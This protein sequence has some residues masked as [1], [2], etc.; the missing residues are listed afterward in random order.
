MN[1]FNITY[2]KA[3]LE[4]AFNLHYAKKFPFRSKVLLI[5]GVILFAIG[6]L[7]FFVDIPKFT[8]M[9][10]LFFFM[11]L[12][13]LAFY[14][15]RKYSL[16]KLAMKNPTIKDMKKIGFDDTIIR[17]EGDEGYFEQELLK[18]NEV[19]HDNDSVLL[20]M[21]KHNFFIIPKRIINSEQQA[22]LLKNLSQQA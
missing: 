20:Y 3:D 11:G 18:F 10:W 2:T 16:I 5:L 14:F 19:F 15:Y 22:S 21:S 13:Y 9:K 12:F 8:N 7:L 6:L 4:A 1:T 17:F